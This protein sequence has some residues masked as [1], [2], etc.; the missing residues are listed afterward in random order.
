VHSSREEKPITCRHSHSIGQHVVLADAR[1]EH[2]I[3]KRKDEG[4]VLRR[5]M[6]GTST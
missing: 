4:Q 6:Q 3:N 2:S 1:W 5:Y